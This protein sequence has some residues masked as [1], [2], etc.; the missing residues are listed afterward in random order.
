MK[1]I[2]LKPMAIQKNCT[3]PCL[4]TEIDVQLRSKGASDHPKK[5]YARVNLDF[6]TAVEKRYRVISY[7]FYNFLIDIGSSLGLWLGISVL[8]LTDIVLQMFV[9]MRSIIHLSKI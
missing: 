5:T 2:D 7:D 8:S 6:D 4:T 3:D 1:L 9:S